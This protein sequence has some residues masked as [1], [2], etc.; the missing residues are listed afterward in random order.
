MYLAP[1]NAPFETVIVELDT[2]VDGAE[3]AGVLRHQ[4]R[5]RFKPERKGAGGQ[6]KRT[7]IQWD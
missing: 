6:K 4:M 3:S 7:A 5:L 2:G 1:Y